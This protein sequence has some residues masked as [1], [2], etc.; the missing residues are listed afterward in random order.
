MI[1]RSRVGS[2]RILGAPAVGAAVLLTIL[3]TVLPAV[4]TP[5]LLPVLTAILPPVGAPILTPDVTACQTE[6]IGWV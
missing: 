3:T 6:P 4:F 1:G 5:I 2:A